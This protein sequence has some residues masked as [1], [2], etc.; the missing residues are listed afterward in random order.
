MKTEQI[1]AELLEGYADGAVNAAVQYIQ[2]QL[3][4][5]DGGF[6]GMFLT[7]EREDTLKAIFKAY[8]VAQIDFDIATKDD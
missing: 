1:Y 5:T 6:A 3:A 2:T 7:G 4:V 8:A